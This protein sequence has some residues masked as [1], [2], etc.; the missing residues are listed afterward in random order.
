[1]QITLI[2]SRGISYGIL[3]PI[4]FSRLM[5]E[6][7]ASPPSI[8]RM[9]IQEWEFQV[10]GLYRVRVNVINP[11]HFRCLEEFFSSN[12]C[13]AEFAL[14]STFSF[15]GH[16]CRIVPAEEIMKMMNALMDVRTEPDAFSS[17]SAEVRY[18][19]FG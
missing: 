14:F 12:L 5:L 9:S 17:R 1:M 8:S 7:F 10:D 15:G 2:I 4:E 3:R 13:P 11:G 18:A 16:E 6:S 19:E